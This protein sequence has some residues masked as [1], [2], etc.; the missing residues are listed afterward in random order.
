MTEEAKLYR[1]EM[2]LKYGVQFKDC[3]TFYD[4]SDFYAGFGFGYIQRDHEA[5]V[6]VEALRLIEKRFPQGRSGIEAKEALK[7]YRVSN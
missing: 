5:K 6:L 2:A 3:P 7:Q 4:R 1:D